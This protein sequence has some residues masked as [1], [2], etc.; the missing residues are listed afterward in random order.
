MYEKNLVKSTLSLKDAFETLRYRR[1][2]RWE[3]PTYF[4]GDGLI[5]FTGPQGSGK[6]LTAVRYACDLM[7]EYPHCKLVTNLMIKDYPIVTLQEF[8]RRYYGLAASADLASLSEYTQKAI[9]EDYMHMNRV[10]PFN[11]ADDLMRYSNL[12]E[13]V[14]YLIDEIQLYFNSLESKNIN[15]DVMV[16]ISQQRKQRKH[17]IATSQ[18]FSRLAKPLREQFNTIVKCGNFFQILQ[19][20]LYLRTEDVQTDSEY[21]NPHGSVD[22]IQWFF[23]RVEDYE[24]YDTYYKV[25]T[26]KFVAGEERNQEIYDRYTIIGGSGTD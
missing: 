1:A 13:G 26:S 10:F 22:Y 16:E 19:R 20:N 23:H 8:I 7:Q 17:I 9:C 24:R 14:V 12:T 25:Q 21:M 5:V 6:T 15:M 2:F 11:D 3:N 4:E 18:V